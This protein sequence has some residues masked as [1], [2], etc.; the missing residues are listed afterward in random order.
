[1]FRVRLPLLSN[2][3]KISKRSTS[4]PPLSLPKI[5]YYDT[6]TTG[7]DPKTYEIISIAAI[8][9]IPDPK[10]DIFTL[11]DPFM[12]ISMKFEQKIIPTCPIHPKASKVNGFTVQDG[13]LFHLDKE[14]TDADQP[15]VALMKFVD[16]LENITT[17]L[18]EEEDET[19]D[20]IVLVAHNNKKFDSNVLAKN[21]AR[22]GF[23]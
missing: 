13:K 3:R 1:M 10:V 12:D 23:S 16:F 14:V 19:K 11:P 17:D 9:D 22:V 2:I 20:K 21:F 4:R 15:R 8:S 18:E 6:E 7:L 5:I